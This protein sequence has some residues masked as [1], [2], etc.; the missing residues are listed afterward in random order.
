VDE[1][2][3]TKVTG[4]KPRGTG[5]SSGGRRLILK[6]LPGLYE[7]DINCLPDSVFYRQGPVV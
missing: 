2:D 3:K 5:R 4:G 6:A 1:G 7:Y